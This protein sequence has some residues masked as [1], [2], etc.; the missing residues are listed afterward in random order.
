MRDH[1]ADIRA[2][3]KQSNAAIDARDPDYV[4]SFMTDDVVVQVAGGPTLTGRIANRDAFAEQMDDKAFGGYRRSPVL[5]V[6]AP[7]GTSANETGTWVGRWRAG[8]R[9][10]EQHGSYSAS[11]R[12]TDVGWMIASESYR[13][14]A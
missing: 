9:A 1:A 4:V 10:H 11:W 13:E 12:L 7:D 3:R 14:E 8:G 6:V 2:L 5:V